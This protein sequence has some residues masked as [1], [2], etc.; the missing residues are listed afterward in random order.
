MD[1]FD[2]VEF[3][4]SLPLEGL[5]RK[6]NGFFCRCP[7]CGDSKRDKRKK[8]CRIFFESRYGHG[9]VTCWNCGLSTT[10]RCFVERV[11]PF[12]FEQYRAK[13]K[14][15]MLE[16]L[17]NG[18]LSAKRKSLS[19]CVPALEGDDLKY[20]FRLNQQTFRPALE[21]AEAIDFCERRKIT[22]HISRLRFCPKKDCMYQGMVIFPFWRD[23][24]KAYGFQGRHWKDKKFLTFS[25]NDSFKVYGAFQVDRTRPITVVES[26][27]DSLSLGNCVAMLGSG[28]SERVMKVLGQGAELIYAFDYDKTGIDRAVKFAGLGRKVFVWPSELKA[29]K[30]FNDLAVAGWA[31]ERIN[32][33]IAENAFTGREAEIRL[34]MKLLEKRK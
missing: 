31:K 30:D 18:T 32:T 33:L 4:Y 1:S 23:E 3:I 19:A 13:E 10:F 11:S 27:I 20:I 29:Y 16:Q 26:I 5:E 21:F 12:I 15:L 7:I 14:S 2:E 34:K 6:E 17:R 28:L 9:V 22:E 8:R 25:P 24:E